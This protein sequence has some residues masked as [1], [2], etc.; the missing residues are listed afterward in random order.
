MVAV[1]GRLPIGDLGRINRPWL[2]APVASA[3]AGTNSVDPGIV[4]VTGR[5]GAKPAPVTVTTR[6]GGL[7]PGDTMSVG[8]LPLPDMP[9]RCTAAPGASSTNRSTAGR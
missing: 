3:T 2:N 4:I 1:T 8:V 7:T 5:C 9:I 6:P